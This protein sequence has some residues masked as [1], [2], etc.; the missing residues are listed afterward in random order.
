MFKLALLTTVGTLVFLTSAAAAVPSVA[1]PLPV[2][3]YDAYGVAPGDM[4]AAHATVQVLLK[5]AGIDVGWRE[6]QA[7]ER[8][9]SA[10][11]SC[12]QAIDTTEILVRIASGAAWS[13]EGALGYSAI[14]AVHQSGSLVTIF[15]DR[16]EVMAARAR[17]DAGT[18]LGRVMAH[19]IGHILL[20]T[21]RHSP[22]GLMRAHWRD[23][24]L[25]RNL[26]SDWTFTAEDAL[27]LRRGLLVRSKTS[28]P[29]DA[30]VAAATR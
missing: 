9:R 18:L 17:V 27:R 28:D 25:Q 4:A 15:A 2:R 5:S 20:G 29:T 16:I 7:R 24:E 23:D 26:A 13:N 19:E 30:V 3:T 11:A 8:S 1:A 14:D 22:T 12:D 10:D 6:C 21:T